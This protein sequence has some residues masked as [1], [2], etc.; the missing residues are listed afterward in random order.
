VNI[1]EFQRCLKILEE[2][3]GPVRV[4]GSM[5]VGHALISRREYA[6]PLVKLAF[7]LEYFPSNNEINWFIRC[8]QLSLPVHNSEDIEKAIIVAIEDTMRRRL[9]ASS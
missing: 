4:V 7:S 3:W 1:D 2:V 5:R 8:G 9:E 6:F